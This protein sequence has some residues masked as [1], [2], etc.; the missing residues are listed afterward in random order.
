MSIAQAVDRLISQ[1]PFLEEALTDNLINVSS[2]A[3]KLRP[4]VEKMLE[5]TCPGRRCSYGY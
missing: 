2:L 1:S 3:R 5:K 4:E